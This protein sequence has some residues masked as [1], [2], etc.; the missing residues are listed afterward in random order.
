V[1][2]PP[3]LTSFLPPFLFS[4]NSPSLPSLLSL[5]FHPL[6]HRFPPSLPPSLPSPPPPGEERLAALQEKEVGLKEGMEEAE[7]TLATAKVGR[8][9]GR[10]GGR[11]EEGEWRR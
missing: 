1:S 9:G 11:E 6:T 5:S 4:F 2:L 7:A 8:E 10:E 3:S